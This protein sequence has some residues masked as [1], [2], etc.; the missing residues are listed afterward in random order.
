MTQLS[1]V[2]AHEVADTPI[3]GALLLGSEI[4]CGKLAHVAVVGETIAADGMSRTSRIAAVA[5]GCVPLVVCAIH[6]GTIAESGRRREGGSPAK[7]NRIVAAAKNQGLDH[8]VLP[9]TLIASSG[10]VA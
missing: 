5:S 3:V 8:T 2:D 4:A 6:A 1:A 9:P 10:A 7:A